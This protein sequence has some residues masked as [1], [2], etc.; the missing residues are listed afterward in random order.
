MIARSSIGDDAGAAPGRIFVRFC[1]RLA[2]LDEPAS[3]LAR[4]GP[5]TTWTMPPTT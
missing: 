1:A 2:M 3:T 5:A 4:T